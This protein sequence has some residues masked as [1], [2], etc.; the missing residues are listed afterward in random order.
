[1]IGPAL[2]LLAGGVQQALRGLLAGEA[3]NWAEMTVYW[4]LWAAVWPAAQ[5]LAWR[6]VDRG[7]IPQSPARK[8]R[9]QR[10]DLISRAIA[11]GAP[12]VDVDSASWQ[13]ALR[14]DRREMS[15]VRWVT[16]GVAAVGAGLIGAAAVLANHNSLGVWVVAVVVAASGV[17]GFLM[18]ASRLRGTRRLLAQTVSG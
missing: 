6:A 2:G 17:A 9:D 8:L 14:D 18:P 4:L 1:L 11:E 12:P 10:F 3:W 13:R 16:V 5:W 15:I 7:L